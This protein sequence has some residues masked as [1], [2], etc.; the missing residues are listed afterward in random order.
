VL[1]IEKCK[2][3]GTAKGKVEMRNF[4]TEDDDTMEAMNEDDIDRYLGHMQSKQIK[5]AQMK[6]K[7]CEEYLNRTKSMLKIK[8]KGKN[9]IKA[10][11]TYA[12]PVLT[13]SF[14]IVKWTP[15]DLENLQTKTRTLLTGYQYL[16]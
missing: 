8:L 5:H 1:G 10:F 13:F 12:T 9:T 15:T 16:I 2:T 7:L 4:T 3:L 6:Q 11:N 14:G